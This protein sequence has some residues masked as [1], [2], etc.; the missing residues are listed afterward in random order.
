MVTQRGT[1]KRLPVP[2]TG[3]RVVTEGKTG[4]VVKMRVATEPYLELVALVRFDDDS[5]ESWY[6][7][8]ALEVQS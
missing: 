8:S 5:G 6:P 1:A 3:S 4:V 7:V 2:N